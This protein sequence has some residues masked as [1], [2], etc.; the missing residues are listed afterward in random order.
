M[1]QRAEEEDQRC[2][3][4]EFKDDDG[5]RDEKTLIDKIVGDKVGKDK[6][7][8]AG[9]EDENQPEPAGKSGM[10]IGSGISAECEEE[11]NTND[12]HD[13][14]HDRDLGYFAGRNIK[15]E[16]QQISEEY[17]GHHDQAI[18]EGT[19][20]PTERFIYD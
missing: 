7:K 6:E 10:A 1:D 14:E 13:G 15:V 17:R 8:T 18:D 20:E 5:K 2:G 19:G 3:D 12:D 4:Q 9:Y 11:S 16:P